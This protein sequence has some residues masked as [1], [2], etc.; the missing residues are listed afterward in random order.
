M[1]ARPAASDWRADPSTQI[2]KQEERGGGGAGGA[3]G[4]AMEAESIASLHACP[5]AATTASIAHGWAPPGMPAA[6][7]IAHAAPT[8]HGHEG[9]PLGGEAAAGGEVA[10]AASGQSSE[11]G[12]LPQLAA[13]P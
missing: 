6:A 10:A 5:P 3:A 13:V 1:E 11:A 8:A 9:G 2:V 4:D 7:P 12:G